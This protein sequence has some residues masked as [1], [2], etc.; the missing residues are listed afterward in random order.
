MHHRRTEV[1]IGPEVTGMFLLDSLQKR[2][3]FQMPGK[4]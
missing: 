3:P 1:E 2:E 4:L